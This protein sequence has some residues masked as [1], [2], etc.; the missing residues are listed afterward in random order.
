VDT[1]Q[2][3]E[4]ENIM[5]AA[6]PPL[7]VA[8]AVLSTDH[9]VLSWNPRAE[10]LTGYSLEAL[11]AIG[12]AQV[13]EPVEVM[14]Q[15]LCKARGGEST[16]SNRLQ[17]KK[18]NGGLLPVEVQCS[19]L[20]SLHCSEP[21]VVVVM[22]EVIPVQPPQR[23]DARQSHLGR[24]AGSLTHEIRNPL[25]AISL[26]IDIV[27]EELR[28]PTLSDRAQ[29]EQSLATIKAEV[30]RLHDLVQEFLSL[31]RSSEDRA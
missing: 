20:R 15:M 1:D 26:H 28:R 5:S 25:N 21:E 2:A 3:I 11:K 17:L 4:T 23:P 18:A 7:E 29:V 12:L 24:L 10:G 8:I 9:T 13:F 14:H 19:P 27:E 16:L 22:R 6:F 31:A 30:M